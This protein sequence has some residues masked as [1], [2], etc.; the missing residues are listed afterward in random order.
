MIEVHYEKGLAK[1]VLEAKIKQIEE[2]A[3]VIRQKHG[4]NSVENVLNYTLLMR[5]L[6]RNLNYINGESSDMI[7]DDYYIYYTFASTQ[8]NKS[9]KIIDDELSDLNL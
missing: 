1:G 7:E 4:D 6:K 9:E 3:D 2:I 8:A 5:A